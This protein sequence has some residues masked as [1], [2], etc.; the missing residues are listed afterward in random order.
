MTDEAAL[1]DRELETLAAPAPLLQSW[2]WGEVQARAGWHVERVRLGAAGMASVQIRS[3]GPAREAYVPRGP[4]PATSEAMTALTGWARN[5]R[6]SR[7]VVEP[8][9]GGE[10]A[11]VLLGQGFTR[12]EPV[13]PRHTRILALAPPEAMLP[14]FKH[15]RRYNI[16]AGGR[17]GVTVEEGGDAAELARQSAA[18]ERRESIHLPDE[19]Y[20]RLL[21]DLLP[22]CRTYVARA[23]E[24]GE[25]L[26]TVLVARHAGRAYSLFAGRSGA[27]SELMGN[28]L[29]WWSAISAAATAGCRDFDLWGVPPPDAGADHPWHGLG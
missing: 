6:V 24:D 19:R 8:E 10:L 21:L 17:R 1:W 23:P 9:A 5:A 28:D 26:A 15:G 14:T 25:P 20:Y 12:A 2:A 11:P 4:V 29:A 18:V 22:W 13:Q 3:V 7:L 27:R 16:R